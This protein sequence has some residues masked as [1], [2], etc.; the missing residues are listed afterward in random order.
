M[1]E[2]LRTRKRHR[3]D[4]LK[5]E[6]DIEF[7]VANKRAKVCED[8][9][10][11]DR[12]SPDIMEQIKD[13]KLDS[14]EEKPV[15][16][17]TKNIQLEATK[18]DEKPTEDTREINRRSPNGFLLPDPL[19][20]GEVL[21]DTIKQQ[22]VLG[23]PIG[24]GGFGELYVA[25]FRNP[26]GKLSPEKFVVKVEPHSNGPLFVE[27]HFYLRATKQEEIEKFKAEKGLSHLG[28]PKLVAN[29]SHVRNRQNYRF[30]VME[31][32]GSDLQ[33]ILDNSEGQRFTTKT[34]CSVAIQVIDS[35][36]YIHRQGYVHKDVK[37]S[38]LLVGLG[39]DGQHLV[40]LVDYGLCSKFRVGSLHKQYRHDIRWAHEGTMEYTS[41][42]AHIGS[43]SRRGDLEVLFYN[44][45]EWFGG[46]LPWDRELASPQV[47]KTAKFLAFRQMG[48]FLRICFRGQK[49]PSFLIKFMKYVS[50]L[51]FEDTPDYDYLRGILCEEIV[52]AGSKLD[53]KL[54]FRLAKLGG[55]VVT[56]D[57]LPPDLLYGPSKKPPSER[58]SSV[59]DKACISVT[60]YE[61][62]R[63]DKWAE[64]SQDSL[65]NPTKAMLDIM[66]KMKADQ[67]L[68]AE[69]NQDNTKTPKG[70]KRTKS[71]SDVDSTNSTPAMMEVM[72]LKKLKSMDDANE[73]LMNCDVPVALLKLPFKLS[74]VTI[75]KEILEE[76]SDPFQHPSESKRRKTSKN[77]ELK[78]L[79]NFMPDIIERRRTRSDAIAEST[80]TQR[81]IRNNLRS[82]FNYG[83]APVRSFMRSFSSSLPKI[84]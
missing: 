18:P 10:S 7:L 62:M 56:P 12:S 14:D 44:L 51:M 61:K 83:M 40:H 19:P 9:S 24:V 57:A 74:P 16:V 49:F 23:K 64:R 76:G 81:E 28:V 63:E 45:I 11:E 60:S 43:A 22:W 32:F 72:R 17:E 26:D 20:R 55:E 47:T 34:A 48:K 69:R 4:Y 66:K 82:A 42:D 39:M 77:K 21:T 79:E 68:K 6:D 30:L 52:N 37:G 84:F 78:R 1:G 15:K 58:V 67:K 38:N 65:Q 31:R 36:E 71:F 70:R 53:G 2:I 29:G 46:S 13:I 41:R 5:V 27:V 54:Q 59:F 3:S 73:E 8:D 25:S 75:T 50:T 35:L 80:R 33:R